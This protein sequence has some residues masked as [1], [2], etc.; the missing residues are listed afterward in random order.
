LI[1]FRP[2]LFEHIEI[3]FTSTLPHAVKD[4]DVTARD[5]GDADAHHRFEAIRAQQRSVPR[6]SWAPVMA[7]DD[8]GRDIQG[9]EQPNEIAGGMERRVCGWVNWS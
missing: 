9:I 6:V 8:G 4:A 5:V 3:V 1:G 7:D 2:D